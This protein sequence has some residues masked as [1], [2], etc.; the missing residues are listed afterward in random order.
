[1]MPRQRVT[2]RRVLKLTTAA[3]GG[4]LMPGGFAMGANTVV[5]PPTCPSTTPFWYRPQ[6]AGIYIDSQRDNKAFARSE[7]KILLSEDNGRTWPHTAAFADAQRI[8]FSHILNNGNVLFATGSKLYLSTD[9]L[10]TYRQITVKDQQGRDYLPHAPKNPSNPGW[11]FHTLPGTISWNVG[12]REMMVW[13]NYCNVS[14]GAAPVN[15]YYSTDSGETVKI[16][17]AFGKN[18][19]FSDNGSPGS[20]TGGTLLGNPDNPVIA[21]HMHCVAYNSVE[22]AFYACTGDHTRPEGL[23]CHWLRGVYDAQA[24]KWQ[25]NVLVSSESNSRYKSCGINIVDGMIYWVSDAN[26]TPPFDRGIFRCCPADITNPNAHE[27][28]FKPEV[29]LGNMIIED[30]VILASHCAPASPLNTGL[31]L[32]TDLGKTW[33]E[34]DLKEFGKRT[35][36]RF[37]PKN[38]DGWFRVDL[39]EG[40]INFA[41]VLFIKPNVLPTRHCRASSRLSRS[42]RTRLN[43]ITKRNRR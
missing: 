9:N 2:R 21:R 32:S 24:D 41:D 11:Y 17:Y 18:P 7:G 3:A 26:G 38:S 15:I 12:G 10:K 1:M 6:P 25:W 35:P 40:W 13:G 16:A 36:T 23:E 34:Y 27:M 4:F 33:A 42:V 28:L 22:D 5:C 43:R 29:E 37:H 14:G 39:R 31:I 19:N 20:G 30:G 8:T